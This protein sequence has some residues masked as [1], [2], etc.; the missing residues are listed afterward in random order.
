MIGSK[1]KFVQQPKKKKKKF[2][3][4]YWPSIS[5]ISIHTVMDGSPTNNNNNNINNKTEMS[6]VFFS[7][8]GKWGSRKRRRWKKPINLC[9]GKQNKKKGEGKK[10]MLFDQNNHT[11]VL[12]FSSILLTVGLM[13]DIHT[14]TLDSINWTFIYVCVCVCFETYI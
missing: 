7:S 2:I 13:D 1:W 12:Y 4:K 10:K 3:Y 8:V 9:K 11:S 6:R 14:H 5:N